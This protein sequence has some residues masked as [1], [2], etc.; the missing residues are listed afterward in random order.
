M[1]IDELA[2]GLPTSGRF[3]AAI[4]DDLVL[5]RSLE[6]DSKYIVEEFD[7]SFQVRQAVYFGCL[8]WSSEEL[9]FL[10]GLCSMVNRRFSGCKLFVDRWGVLVM[11]SDIL[12]AVASIELI[13]IILDQTEFMSQATLG[14]VEA[15]RERGSAITDEE[16]DCAL[17]LPA[18][19]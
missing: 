19:H 4:D 13:E 5:V 12:G 7:G 18:L 16:L 9:L 14:L 8:E 17:E 3:A 11:A 10:Y 15:I 6:T 2:S 1:R